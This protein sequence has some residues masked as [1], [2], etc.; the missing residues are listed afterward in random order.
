MIFQA[1]KI[2][3]YLKY[4][5]V[6]PHHKGH[7]VHSPF[8]F[9]FVTEVLCDKNKK[10]NQLKAIKSIRQSLLKN[11][12]T[13]FVEDKG[14][15][16]SKI[17]GAQRQI[18]AIARHSSTSLKYGR[19]LY[20]IVSHYQPSTIIELGSCLGTGTLYLASGNEKSKVYTI[21]GSKTLH[22]MAQRSYKHAGLSNIYAHLGIFDDVLPSILKENRTF[23][24]VY[25]DGN[26]TK[27]ATFRYFHM[28]LPHVNS[29]SII[30]FDDIRWSEEMEMAWFEICKHE[31]VKLS[32]DLFNLG[33]VFCNEHIIKQHF[34]LYY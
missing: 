5:I 6:R 13:I 10:D 27:E 7:G 3:N 34:E 16:S 19:L 31:N 28:L 22:E 4:K 26:H 24:L 30:I 23:D 1:K 2:I 25:I 11:K 33:I 9:D 17:M 18:S 15:G 21:E 14:A 12:E 8:L 20:R 32:V 29:H